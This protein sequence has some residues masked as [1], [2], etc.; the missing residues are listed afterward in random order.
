MMTVRGEGREHGGGD[1]DGDGGDGDG[2]GG[3]GDGGSGDGDDDGGNSDCMLTHSISSTER[4]HPAP[5]L[6]PLEIIAL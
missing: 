5:S 2:D 6:L 3:G 1:G 4:V